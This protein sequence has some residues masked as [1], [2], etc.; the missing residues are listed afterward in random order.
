MIKEIKW[1]R[2][3]LT[4]E[5]FPG[6]IFLGGIFLRTSLTIGSHSRPKVKVD[7]NGEHMATQSIC[8]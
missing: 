5:N 6:G 8:S 2:I 3:D 4:Y 7:P 1:M